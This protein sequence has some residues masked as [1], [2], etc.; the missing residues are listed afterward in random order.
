MEKRFGSSDPKAGD[1]K[2]I[3]LLRPGWQGPAELPD[4]MKREK[5]LSMVISLP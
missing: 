5:Y 2:W 3:H 4:H 1:L